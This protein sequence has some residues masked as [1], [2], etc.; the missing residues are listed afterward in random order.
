MAIS[1]GRPENS[2]NFFAGWSDAPP[3]AWPNKVLEPTIALALRLSFNHSH[4]IRTHK[5]RGTNCV[6]HENLKGP[7]KHMSHSKFKSAKLTLLALSCF[8]LISRAET[9]SD[10][11]FAPPNWAVTRIGDGTITRTSTAT[12]G[13]PSFHLQVSHQGASG[14][15]YGFHYRLLFAYRPWISGPVTS[16]SWSMDE[17]AIQNFNGIGLG[18]LPALSQGGNHYFPNRAF[19]VNSDFNWTTFSLTGL[20]ASD[21]R[22]VGNPNAHPDFSASGQLFQP[23]FVTVADN[24]T[25]IGSW[26]G[27]FD[28]WVFD[29]NPIPEPGAL[30][31][32]G[33]GLLGL[34]WCAL[35]RRSISSHSHPQ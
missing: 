24:G 28:N 30:S 26:I 11:G 14:V 31:L 35:R 32:L 18:V 4:T 34:C 16:I 17:I 27:G 10:S 23:G 3:L 22:T 6:I 33:L 8:S 20:T 13:N 12:G 2:A 9:F 19:F 29:V 7:Q 15:Q 1:D 5:D 25:D 21:F